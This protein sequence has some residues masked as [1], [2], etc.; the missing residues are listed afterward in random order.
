[1]NIDVRVASPAELVEVGGLRWDSLIENGGEPESAR[2]VFAQRFADWAG[3]NGMTHTCFVAVSVAD[4]SVV[5]MTWLAVTRRVPSARAFDRASGDLQ[6]AYV[7]PELR[8]GGVGSRLVRAVLDRAKEQGLERV[9]VHSS[10]G[11]VRFYKRAGFATEDVL[12]HVRA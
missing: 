5:G 2:E 10:P 9:T 8:S 6:C 12:L 11:A 1:M 7:R 3:A 4:G